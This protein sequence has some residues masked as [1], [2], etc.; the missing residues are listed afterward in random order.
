MRLIVYSNYCDD[1]KIISENNTV[2][3]IIKTKFSL[4]NLLERFL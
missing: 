1:E 3:Q 4:K 2:K